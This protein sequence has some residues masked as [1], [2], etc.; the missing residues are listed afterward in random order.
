MLI[1]PSYYGFPSHYYTEKYPNKGSKPVADKV[2][3]LL[4][5]AGIKTQ[6]TRRGLDHGVFV[7]F[8]VG[9]LTHISSCP[10][11]SKLTPHSI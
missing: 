5:S 9:M 11:N 7:V 3:G 10:L 4:N 6:A 1:Y 2:I 8:K